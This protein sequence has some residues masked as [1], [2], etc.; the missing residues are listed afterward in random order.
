MTS[1]LCWWLTGLPGAGKTTL[2]TALVAAL[3]QRGE[4]ACLLDGDEIRLGLCRDLGFSP[5]A[6]HENMRRVA[7]M[8]CLLNKSG[9]HAVVALVSPT[10]DGRALA[11]GIIGEARFLEVHVATPLE[12]C[13]AR[14]P[15]G[16]YAK[17][18]INPAMGMTG[19]QAGYE[20]PIAPALSISTQDAHLPD[21]LAQLLALHA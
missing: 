12:V 10:I 20:A 11:R 2:A 6:R 9:I 17:A 21:L 8:A 1:S 7:E 3:Q 16:L 18:R 5:E 13:Q 15:K 14:D 4:P 19:V